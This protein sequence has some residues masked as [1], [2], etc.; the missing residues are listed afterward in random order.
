MSVA[1]PPIHLSFTRG[2]RE[3]RRRSRQSSFARGGLRGA[4]LD[5]QPACA[6]N[7]NHI[8]MRVRHRH[9]HAANGVADT[10]GVLGLRR[11]AHADDHIARLSVDR[12][13][14]PQH[15]PEVAMHA[16]VEGSG[17]P[18]P[19]LHRLTTQ[20]STTATRPRHEPETVPRR[21]LNRQ[22]QAFRTHASQLAVMQS[23]V[24]IFSSKLAEPLGKAWIDFPRLPSRRPRNRSNL[25]I[26]CSV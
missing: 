10:K 14:H 23:A 22:I 21:V 3:A 25:I 7:G 8:S 1:T 5:L 24:T 15:D 11:L 20:W 12:A 17:Q 9:R 2:S 4:L 19:R 6:V 18:D 16:L 13:R 26:D